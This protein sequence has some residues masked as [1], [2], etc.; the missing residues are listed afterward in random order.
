MLKNCYTTTYW[1]ITIIKNYCYY[2][3]ITIITKTIIQELLYY[4]CLIHAVICQNYA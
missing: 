1:S 2:A 4:Y 3:T